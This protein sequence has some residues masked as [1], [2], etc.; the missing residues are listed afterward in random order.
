MKAEMRPALTVSLA[1]LVALV[2]TS[3]AHDGRSRQVRAFHPYRIGPRPVADKDLDATIREWIGRTVY[4]SPDGTGIDTLRACYDYGIPYMRNASRAP[5]DPYRIESVR[6]DDRFAHLMVARLLGP[7]GD[8]DKLWFEN[9]PDAFLEAISAD[10]LLE[11][12]VARH[13]DWTPETWE[14]IRE[15]RPDPGMSPD[16]VRLAIGEPASVDTD[17]DGRPRWTYP[18]FGAIL[19]F[20]AASR[21][22]SAEV[23][24]PWL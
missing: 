18:W 4:V 9:D 24:D 8:V 2:A 22:V 1:V 19:T 3:C 20:D 16:M 15:Q 6:R 13:P 21:L 10:F 17:A 7:R 11:D 23:E 5:L 14:A 12:P